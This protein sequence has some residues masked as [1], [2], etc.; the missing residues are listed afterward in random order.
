MHTSRRT[1]LVGAAATTLLF[2]LTACGGDSE[3][4]DSAAGKYKLIKPGVITAA[5][6]SEQ[7]PFAVA[8]ADGKPSGFAVDLMNRAAKRL[9]VKVQYKT[10]SLPGMLAGLSAGQYD[11]GVA[12]VGNT[13]ERK[14]QVGFTTPY[15]WGYTDVLTNKSGKQTK[16]SDFAG[17]RVGV[18]T[19]SVQ[20][21]FIAKRMPDA[22]MVKFKD[23]TALISQLRTGGTEAA[24]LGGA[25]ADEYV[26]KEPVRIAVKKQSLQGAA[27]PMRKDGDP[28]LVKDLDAQIDAMID[29][30]TYI[31]LYKKYFQDTI[32][33][34]LIKERPRLAKQVENTSLAPSQN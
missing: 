13:P 19:G 31:K 21:D 1:L 34:D 17:K 7:P 24:V 25:S 5:T 4:A 12:G 16:L 20:E 8:D 27:F 9:G 2:S 32:A 26:A 3:A 33:A 14:K 23:Q 15:Y 11:V 10:T 6:Q 28:K 29:D 22:H 18:V 30:G